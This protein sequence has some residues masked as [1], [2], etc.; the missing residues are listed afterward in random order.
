MRASLPVITTRTAGSPESVAQF[1]SGYI[2]PERDPKSL[3]NAISMLISDPL[4]RQTMG[5]VGRK[6]YDRFFTFDIMAYNTL[7]IYE[8]VLGITLSEPPALQEYGNS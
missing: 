6:R 7:N 1:Q 2:V 5:E 3:A 8:T 4:R